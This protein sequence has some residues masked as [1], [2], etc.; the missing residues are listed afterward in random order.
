MLVMVITARCVPRA[1]Q[2]LYSIFHKAFVSSN[3]Q[4][5]P[6][7]T[8]NIILT[9]WVEKSHRRDGR[10]FLCPM[11]LV[12]IAVEI[13]L[14]QDFQ[15][16]ILP[17]EKVPTTSCDLWYLCYASCWGEYHLYLTDNAS[18]LS[19]LMNPF[20][21]IFF[22]LVFSGPAWVPVLGIWLWITVVCQSLTYVWLFVTPWTVHHQASLSFS[23]NF[24]KTHAHW[25]NDAIQP[26]PPLSPAP[27][28]ALNRP[29]IRV[30][31]NK[32]A[33]HNKWSNYWSF[34]CSISPSTEYSVLISFRND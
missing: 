19:P 29:S 15:K 24:S 4:D 27:P 8:I 14:S 10:D 2:G 34:S 5:N 6:V 17:R 20:F 1:F 31:S 22:I 16:V 26:S 25:V 11:Q 32:W 7:G 23:L 18:L 13:P 3:P 28:P 33:L 12:G 9:L 21:K 30:F